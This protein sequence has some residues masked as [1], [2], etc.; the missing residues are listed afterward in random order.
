MQSIDHIFYNSVL[1]SSIKRKKMLVVNTLFR[2]YKEK[3]RRNCD[4]EINNTKDMGLF[5]HSSE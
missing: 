5:A 1:Q 4:G 3:K 2:L